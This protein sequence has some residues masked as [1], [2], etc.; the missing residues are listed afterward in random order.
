M[1]CCFQNGRAKML[2][3]FHVNNVL[4]RCLLAVLCVHVQS[5]TVHKRHHIKCCQD[6]ASDYFNVSLCVTTV[7]ANTCCPGVQSKNLAPRFLPRLY[8]H[9]CKTNC[10][11]V[12]HA[13]QHKPFRNILC[14]KSW[15]WWPIGQRNLKHRVNGPWS[16]HSN[17]MPSIK[18]IK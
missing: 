8:T 13:K 17:V 18:A 7:A 10:K 2:C 1:R 6:Q 15:Y 5:V 3:G 9:H 14:K 12:Q 16:P 11:F 4:I